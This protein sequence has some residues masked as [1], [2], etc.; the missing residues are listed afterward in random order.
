[1]SLLFEA[2]QAA[3]RRSNSLASVISHHGENTI[4]EYLTE[5]NN[6][7]GKGYQG[8]DDLKQVVFA[9]AKDLIGAETAG[10]ASERLER[11]SG[12]LTSNHQ[13]G[14]AHV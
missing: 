13:I 1:M 7:G 4:Q 14:R 5:L 11:D 8:I 6:N 12:I 9:Y 2:L 3:C 10:K